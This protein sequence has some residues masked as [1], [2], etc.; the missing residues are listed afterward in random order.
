MTIPGHRTCYQMQQMTPADNYSVIVQLQRRWLIN[1]LDPCFGQSQVEREEERA[2]CR[3]LGGL[4]E[5]DYELGG[6]GEEVVSC[7]RFSPLGQ[8]GGADLLG[9]KAETAGLRWVTVLVHEKQHPEWL[10]IPNSSL[11][12]GP[13]LPAPK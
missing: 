13:F 4:G 5:E 3:E 9:D 2:Q 11:H 8:G 10:V 1:D 7:L 12:F 6:L